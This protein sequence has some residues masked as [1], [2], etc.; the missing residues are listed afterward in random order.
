MIRVAL[1]GGSEPNR[2][3]LGVID[4]VDDATNI[5]LFENR[6]FVR[7]SNYGNCV[8]F[9]EGPPPVAAGKIRKPRTA[10]GKRL[11]SLTPDWLA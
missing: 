1:L 10:K 9:A 8:I 6:W 3:V 11:N 2:E 7:E 5:M 4:D